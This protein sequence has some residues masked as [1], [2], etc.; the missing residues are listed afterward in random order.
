VPIAKTK[1]FLEVFWRRKALGR[2]RGGVRNGG[3]CIR[4][5]RVAE[6]QFLDVGFGDVTPEEAVK[7][8]LEVTFGS[9]GTD[10][11]SL[12]GDAIGSKLLRQ[13]ELGDAFAGPG[14]G[15]WTIGL[16]LEV[17]DQGAAEDALISGKQKMAEDIQQESPDG[18]VVFGGGVEG[19]GCLA[20][21]ASALT[22]EVGGINPR[23]KFSVVCRQK[24]SV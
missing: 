11:E 14:F 10:P 23:T 1:G 18:I 19:Q 21:D 5:R 6:F 15:P 9:I 20:G 13:P 17:L 8:V 24:A 12:G 4:R 22:P 3:I 16:I 7:V 2:L